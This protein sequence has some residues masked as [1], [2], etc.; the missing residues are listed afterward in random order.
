MA[1][2]D[3]TME[4]DAKLKAEGDTKKKGRGHRE[5]QNMDERYGR[6][7]FSELD[8]KAAPGP[9]A[10]V[11]GWVVIVTGVHEEAQEEDLHEAFSEF[12]EIKNIYLNL[13]RQTGFVKGYAL[14][15]YKK[16]TE[17]KAAIDAMNG[18]ELL[19]QKIKVDYAFKKGDIKKGGRR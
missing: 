11:E 12:G 8:P 17:A 4:E 18:A 15:E 7:R 2:Y 13:D 5:A 1:D 10:S 16:K 9:T 14:I 19:T 3:E 6:A